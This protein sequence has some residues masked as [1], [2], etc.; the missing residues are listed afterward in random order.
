[1]NDDAYDSDE[2]FGFGSGNGPVAAGSTQTATV[3]PGPAG[4]AATSPPP[5][6]LAA[7]TDL[8][9]SAI[10]WITL[11]AILSLGLVAGQAKITAKLR[12]GGKK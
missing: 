10:S 5:S 2:Y 9:G 1:M 11:A 8:K 4:R 3:T 6:A 7:I 12:A